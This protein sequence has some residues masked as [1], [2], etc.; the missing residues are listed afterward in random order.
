MCRPPFCAGCVELTLCRV[1]AR[2]RARILRRRHGLSDVRGSVRARRGRSLVLVAR[3]RR[4]IFGMCVQVFRVHTV[5]SIWCK[6]RLAQDVSG[7]E[8]RVIASCQRLLVADGSG[9]NS[10]WCKG[11]FAQTVLKQAKKCQRIVESENNSR[12]RDWSS[13]CS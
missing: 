8:W 9:V 1:R 2:L 13:K 6:R 12:V 3:E 4:R 10:V 7:V 5:T 11:C